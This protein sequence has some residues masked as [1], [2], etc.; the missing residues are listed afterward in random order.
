MT[1]S[2]ELRKAGPFTGNGVTTAF[3]FSFKVFAATDVTVTVAN[4]QGSESVLA[5]GAGGIS[6]CV[7]REEEKIL[8]APNIANIEQYIDRVDEMIER[9]RIVFAEKAKKL[10]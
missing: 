7:M 1:I 3:P 8:R 2:T 10:D 9:K 5:L 4:T 6:K